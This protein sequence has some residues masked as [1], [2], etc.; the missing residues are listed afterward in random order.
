MKIDRHNDFSS[1]IRTWAVGI[2]LVLACGIGGFG[3]GTEPAENEDPSA[4]PASNASEKQEAGATDPGEES[5]R[6][7]SLDL[8]VPPSLR[9][10]T[11]SLDADEKTAPRSPSDTDV[12]AP[13]DDASVS[14]ERA[15]D[16]PSETIQAER[17]ADRLIRDTIRRLTAGPAFDAKL[18][19]HIWAHGREVVGVG[20][21]EQAG[22]ETGWFSMEMM[23][24]TASGKCLLQQMSD[25]RL[26]WTREQVGER[27]RLRRVDV[28]RLDEL[29][30]SQHGNGS[31]PGLRVGGL[32]ELLQRIHTDYRLVRT[33]G[34]V[35][36]RRVWVLRG[37]LREHV[38]ESIAPSNGSA[39]P[40]LCPR[41]VLVAIA[42]DRNEQGFGKGLLAR[43]E[44]WSDR[45]DEVD[46]EADSVQ[47]AQRNLI[48]LLKIY[49]ARRI[50]PAPQQH[51]S[52]E[53][54]E[55]D[56]QF[57]NDTERYVEMFG[58]KLTAKERVMLLR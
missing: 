44:F 23:I 50:N 2:L 32:V 20:R 11:S 47:L 46:G 17:A 31:R 36:G 53:T 42:A 51:F 13:I 52:F 48:S 29:V 34:R 25:G 16:S 28:G 37:S 8:S 33:A 27:V 45:P 22:E 35:D 19:Q 15:A 14:T 9:F 58:V 38:A 21:Y 49:D 40:G 55:S 57:I 5:L 7:R 6:G 18:T 39:W 4:N 54:G 56:V 3:A 30:P 24:P 1:P 26:A 41:E 12:A 43:I 10:P